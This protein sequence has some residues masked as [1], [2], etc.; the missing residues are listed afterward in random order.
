VNAP[1]KQTSPLAIVSLV[2]G[3]VGWL[4]IPLLGAIVAIVTGHM[5][6]AEIRRQPET[7]EGDGLAL[8]G[9]ILGYAWFALMV[10]VVLVVVLLFGGFMAAAGNWH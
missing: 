10:L 1:I 5:A 8:A 6:R 9:M 4:L 7:M 3:I 2:S